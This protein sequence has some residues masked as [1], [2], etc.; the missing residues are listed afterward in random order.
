MADVGDDYLERI[1]PMIKISTNGNWPQWYPTRI[2]YGADGKARK[3]WAHT[4]TPLL[5]RFKK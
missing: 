1:A 2:V 4:S 5:K 3:L